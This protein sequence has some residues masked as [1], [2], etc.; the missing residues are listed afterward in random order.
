[1]RFPVRAQRTWTAFA[2]ATWAAVVGCRAEPGSASSGAG[3]AGSTAA[4]TGGNGAAVSSGG[5]SSASGAGS[6][7][8][9]S[10]DG[11]GGGSGTPG[12]CADVSGDYGPCESEIG[13]AFNGGECRL[14]SGCNCAPN[15]GSFFDDAISCAAACAAVGRCDTADMK[16]I[17][18]AQDPFVPGNHCD[19]V[20]I[21][22]DGDN[23]T[24]LGALFP[25]WTCEPQVGQL[26]TSG[27]LCVAFWA[28]TVTTKQ[29]ESLC[30]ASLLPRIDDIFCAVYGP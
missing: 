6:D 1:M 23:R 8:G 12:T 5:G 22:V 29:W 27:T 16:A 13:W 26:C 17:F 9:M 7:G 20:D 24:A 21:C 30:A 25:E 14:F 2:L 11:G 28:G 10:A 3:G 4:A 18:L 15:C 19:E